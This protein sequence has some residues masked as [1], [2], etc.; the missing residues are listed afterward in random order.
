MGPV[1]KA[2]WYIESHYEQAVSLDEV[3]RVAGVSR[4]YLSRAF[5]EVTGLPLTRYL[6]Y[7]R[8][9][10]A[11][12]ALAAGKTDILDLALSLGYSSHEAFSR[13]FKELFGVTPESVR[14][15]GDVDNLSLLRAQKTGLRLAENL[16]EPEVVRSDALCLAGLSK[17][18][19]AAENAEIPGQWQEFAPKLQQLADETGVIHGTETFGV[20]SHTDDGSNYSYLCAV[21][22]SDLESISDDL[23]QLRIPP[24]SYAVFSHSAHISQVRATHAAIWSHGLPT[25]GRRALNAPF[26]ERYSS[27]FNPRTGDGGLEIWIPIE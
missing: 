1:E 3:A 24:R 21:Q 23:T 11:A 14:R 20:Y 13:A 2:I 7:R 26:F 12:R 8:L 9:S 22:V 18:Y 17:E 10:Q 6:R 15:Q 25:L 5:A 16:S 19:S 27:S 4:F